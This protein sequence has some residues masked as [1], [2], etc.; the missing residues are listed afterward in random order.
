[1]KNKNSIEKKIART[2]ISQK[3]I[4]QGEISTGKKTMQVDNQ[5]TTDLTISPE[6]SIK[7][8]ETKE[9]YFNNEEISQSNLYILNPDNSE[10]STE[11]TLSYEEEPVQT[12]LQDE[13]E[14]VCS[15]EQT[16]DPIDSFIEDTPGVYLLRAKTLFECED[17][18]A[19]RK[20]AI[21][22]VRDIERNAKIGWL[23]IGIAAYRVLQDTA[24]LP[25]GSG[26][27]DD[28]EVGRV[29][30]LKKFAQDCSNSGAEI[31][32]TTLYDY[33]RWVKTLLEE[34]LEKF[35]GD[36]KT[37]RRERTILMEKLFTFPPSIA[38][39]L[40]TGNFAAEKLEVARRLED[41][42]DRAATHAEIRKALKDH[43]TN[44]LGDVA[45]SAG[46]ND[47]SE[48]E[49]SKT[50]GV[51]SEA[52]DRIEDESLMALA[53]DSQVNSNIAELFARQIYGEARRTKLDPE[54][55]KDLY[56]SFLQMLLS[57]VRDMGVE[58]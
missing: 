29:N 28:L 50:N 57:G 6:I 1:M 9:N 31:S 20:L 7:N 41:E 30:A 15:H 5:A 3:L 47:S 4:E 22:T 18:Q 8:P 43:F 58:K 26:K 49:E 48:I 33:S 55:V 45:V 11:E 38:K 35:S 16:S 51:F 56:V 36:E 44:K 24:P 27:K 13:F 21:K 54:K 32:Y 34:P 10:C 17:S 53:P 40:S 23:L 12:T 46:E 14:E 19:A 42:L 2:K 37:L 39:T 52:N 25:G